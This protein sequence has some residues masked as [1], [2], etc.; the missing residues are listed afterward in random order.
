[1]H[2][3]AL[4][5][6]PIRRLVRGLTRRLWA[7]YET[8][9]MLL[10]WVTFALL[11]LLALPLVWVLSI[12]PAHAWVRRMARG[13][14]HGV[15][16]FYLGFLRFFCSNHF[17][18]S[19]L[20]ALKTAPAHVV[21][22][23][24]PSLMDVVLIVSRLPN[25]VCIMKAGLMD[26]ILLGA[27]ARAAGYIRNDNPRTMMTQA[28]VALKEGAHVLIFPE[29]GR[30]QHF[31]LDHFGKSAALI[32]KRAG[33]PIQTVLIT[34]STPYLGK[35]WPLWRRPALPLRWATHLGAG[36]AAPTHIS[37]C[38]PTLEASVR[39]QLAHSFDHSQPESQPGSP[40]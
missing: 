29:G 17:D 4:P 15:F 27:A 16:H 28:H 7:A 40:T 10:G 34:F 21:I 39:A 24:H 1:M 31:P 36:F 38:T 23:N 14:I 8:L 37:Q 26:N 33:V 11:C 35:Q 6:A 22:A 9:A 20:D 32:A 5:L 3:A 30:T 13:T 12:L 19:E 25:V 2:F 18:L